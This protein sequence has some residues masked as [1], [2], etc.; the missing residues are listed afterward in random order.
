M[1]TRFKS[2]VLAIAAAATIAGC[3]IRD[4]SVGTGPITLSA[5]AERAFDQY[6]AKETPRYFAVS[7]DGLAYYYSYCDAG[8]CL[9][10]P[11]TQVVRKCESYSEGVPCRIYGSQGNIVWAKDG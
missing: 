6:R 1:S 7:E 11:K 9:R 3:A 2:I 5:D 8:R 4:P 10:Q